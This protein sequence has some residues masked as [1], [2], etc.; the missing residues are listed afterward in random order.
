MFEC[1]FEFLKSCCYHYIWWQDS[2]VFNGGQWQSICDT[3]SL[4]PIKAQRSDG[5][6]EFYAICLGV[7]AQ[8][9]WSSVRGWNTTS[10]NQEDSK[11]SAAHYSI[12]DAVTDIST[13]DHILQS[14]FYIQ[15]NVRC[16]QLWTSGQYP[17][18]CRYSLCKS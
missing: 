9:T 6:G 11:T 13:F 17:T 10:Y 3:I 8:W 15:S 5:F 14:T 1:K 12:S 16:Q 2:L 18:L 4:S 7:V